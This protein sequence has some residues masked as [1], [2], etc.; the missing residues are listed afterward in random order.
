[1]SISKKKSAASLTLS[2]LTKA[3]EKKVKETNHGSL[4]EVPVAELQKIT[5]IGRGCLQPTEAAG[6]LAG[7]SIRQVNRANVD[8]LVKTLLAKGFNSDF[9]LTVAIRPLGAAAKGE[10]KRVE[11]S[12]VSK[13]GRDKVEDMLYLDVR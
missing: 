12:D 7:H 4:K 5:E 6:L 3:L 11:V 13:G 2:S 1:M 10:G 9:A 8:S